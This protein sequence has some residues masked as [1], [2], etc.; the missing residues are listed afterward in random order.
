MRRAI[1]KGAGLTYKDFAKV[2]YL[3]FG[4]S[5]ELMKN[6]QLD[7]TLISAGLGVAAVRDLATAVNSNRGRAGTG[8]GGRQDRRSRLQQPATIPAKSYEG[9][10]DPVTTVAD[11][12]T[13]SSLIQ[14]VPAE[15]WFMQ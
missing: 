14:G 15:T 13:S 9:Q 3:P 8:R 11:P 12:E 5:V 7:A 1:F 6:R 4:E 10:T 2:E